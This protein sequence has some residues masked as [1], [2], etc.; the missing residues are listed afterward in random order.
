MKFQ[1]LESHLRL[2]LPSTKTV[3]PSPDPATLPTAHEQSALPLAQALTLA[4]P[5]VSQL[6][7]CKKSLKS[8]SGNH[9]RQVQKKIVLSLKWEEHGW[10]PRNNRLVLL[11]CASP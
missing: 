2:L 4:E 11:K 10:G 7:R 6:L 1:N 5:I 8:V 3:I 9:T